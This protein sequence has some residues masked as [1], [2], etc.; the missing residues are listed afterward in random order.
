MLK[1]HH[2]FSVDLW[3]GHFAVRPFFFV[4]GVECGSVYSKRDLFGQHNNITERK[5]LK[6]YIIPLEGDV[7]RWPRRI[8]WDTH[9]EISFQFQNKHSIR[10]EPTYLSPLERGCRSVPE[11][12]SRFGYVFFCCCP[13][14]VEQ[15]NKPNS[16]E[17]NPRAN[18]VDIF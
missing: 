1:I 18:I 16:E 6:T 10:G 7:G 5:T 14:F 4:V 17:D 13:F 11:N 2:Q 12:A 3:S 9:F 15:A 8:P